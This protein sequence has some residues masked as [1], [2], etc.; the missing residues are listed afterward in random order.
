MNP[1]TVN[2]PAILEPLV[3]LKQRLKIL[4]HQGVQGDYPSNSLPALEAAFGVADCVEFDVY[5]ATDAHGRPRIVVIHPE[6]YFLYVNKD[7]MENNGALPMTFEQTQSIKVRGQPLIPTLE[8]VLDSHHKLTKERGKST[9]I[10]I[11]LKGPGVAEYLIPMLRQRVASGELQIED[12]ALTS[13]CYPGDRT[14][15]ERARELDPEVRLV[16]VVRGGDFRQD[17]FD[18]L[19]DVIA[20]AKRIEAD[21]IIGSRRLMDRELVATLRAAGF[22]VGCYHSRTSDE[23][24]A[25]LA[26]DVD[27]V[28]ADYYLGP[29]VSDYPGV[30]PQGVA[31]FGELTQVG[32]YQLRDW[33]WELGWHCEGLRSNLALPSEYDHVFALGQKIDSAVS[34]DP[35]RRQSL[36]LQ[37]RAEG[38]LPARIVDFSTIE[39]PAKFLGAT[40]KALQKNPGELI[41]FDR[42]LSPEGLESSLRTTFAS[43]LGL[44]PNI[45]SVDL[46]RLAA[47]ITLEQAILFS[48]GRAERLIREL[49]LDLNPDQLKFIENLSTE[50]LIKAGRVLGMLSFT[51]L[52]PRHAPAEEFVTAVDSDLS[53][54]SES[55]RFGAAQQIQAQLLR[56]GKKGKVV[57]PD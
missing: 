32:F 37:L 17:G 54:E 24:G 29:K 14:R 39:I 34:F 4:A 40:E 45:T 38:N 22:K 31:L 25:T 20:F 11:E 48:E 35:N 49:G 55:V 51:A 18:D 26:L 21:T 16:L 2:D 43:V 30:L 27:Y 44:C 57:F 41:S 23:L 3:E 13:L 46:E 56:S 53:R 10:H 52:C 8:A 12:F 19:D 6:G 7:G 47:A 42:L 28:A 36:L 9:E 33:L 15:L 50:F 5:L 1:S